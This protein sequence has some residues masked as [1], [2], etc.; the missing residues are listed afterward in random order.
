MAK[1]ATASTIRTVETRRDKPKLWYFPGSLN[2]SKAAICLRLSPVWEDLEIRILVFP[3]ET[4]S[5]EYARINPAMG[6]PTLEIDDKII[7]GS[8]L[9][10]KYLT[11]RYPGRGDKEAPR[12]AIDQFIQVMLEW[13]EGLWSYKRMPSDMGTWINKLKELRCHENLL[14]AIERGEQGEVLGDGPTVRQAYVKKIAWIRQMEGTTGRAQEDQAIVQKRHEV[15]DASL[16]AMCELA[17]KLLETNQPFMFG[18]HLTSADG[19]FLCVLFRISQASQAELDGLLGKTKHCAKYWEALK[20]TKESHY[21]TDYGKAW[22]FRNMLMNRVPFRLLGLKMGWMRVPELPDDVE[23]EVQESQRARQREY[24]GDA[25]DVAG[26]SSSDEESEESS[27]KDDGKAEKARK[28]G[29]AC[30]R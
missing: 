26:S 24:F 9:I 21:V 4:Q 12:E 16:V 3:E 18:K 6:I 1:F 27:S 5:L 23:A 17:D 7:A 14:G 10:Q 22:S 28:K 29:K 8:D 2:A 11:E 13:D 25:L 19:F 20:A 15:N 30:C